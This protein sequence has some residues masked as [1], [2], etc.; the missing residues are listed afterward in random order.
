MTIETPDIL[1]PDGAQAHLRDWKSRVDR[2]AA[3]TQAMSDRLGRLRVHGTD[4]NDLV[5]VTIDTNGGLVDIR[6]TARIQRVAPAVVEQAVMS[7]MRS[8]RAS[9]ARQ[10]REIIVETMGPDSV[11]AQAIAARIAG[12]LNHD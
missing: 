5:E 1:D 10:A 8:A 9:A 4:D 6:F 7:A 2:M 12:Q 11:A 3:D